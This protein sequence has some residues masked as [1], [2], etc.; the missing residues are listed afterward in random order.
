MCSGTLPATHAT[1]NRSCVRYSTFE[2]KDKVGKAGFEVLTAVNT[3]MAVFWFVAPCS[4]V[5]VY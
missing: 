4:P 5:E 2:A 3:K 1:W